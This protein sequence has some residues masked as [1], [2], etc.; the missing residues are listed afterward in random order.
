M[1][2]IKAIDLCAGAGGWGC[3]ARGLP[4][5]IVLAVDLWPV[6]CKTYELNHPSTRVL[7]G[8]L[9]DGGVRAAV[10]EAEAFVA[11]FD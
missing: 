3:A 11:K 8:D 9:R 2:R 6:A 7:C 1:D 4:I 5:D 10:L